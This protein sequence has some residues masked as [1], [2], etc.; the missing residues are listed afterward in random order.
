LKAI[1]SGALGAAF[2]PIS[3]ISSGVA[4]TVTSAAAISKAAFPVGRALN[5]A[6]AAVPGFAIATG[7]AA[8]FGGVK[9]FFTDK[10]CK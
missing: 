2:D 5:I 10:R 7:V 3:L 1:G 6:R 8:T 4:G 9:A